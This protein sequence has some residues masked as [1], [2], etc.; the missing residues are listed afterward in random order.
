MKVRLTSLPESTVQ[1]PMKVQLTSVPETNYGTEEEG[2]PSYIARNVA[3]TGVNVASTA[4][5]LPTNILGALGTVGNLVGSG[6][7]KLRD[8]GG[9]TEERIGRIPTEKIPNIS[10]YTV[11]PLAKALLPEGYTQPQTPKEERWDELTSDITSLMLPIKGLTTGMKL[12]RAAG[13]AGA[14]GLAKWA[15]HEAGA[16]EGTQTGVK[17]GTMLGMSLLGPTRMKDYMTKQYE[18]AESAIPKSANVPSDQIEKSFEGIEKVLSKGSMTPSKKFMADRINEVRSKIK[19]GKIPVDE[20][21]EF[22]RNMNEYMSDITSPYGIQK[23]LPTITKGLNE[24]LQKYGHENKAFGKAF[25]EAEDFYRGMNN[26]TPAAKFLK[27][28]VN[29]EKIGKVTAG[30]LMGYLP[31]AVGAKL[32]GAGLAAKQSSAMFSMVKNS[33]AIRR[34]YG[35]LMQAALRE[36]VP[37]FTKNLKQLDTQISKEDPANSRE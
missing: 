8:I 30:M 27:K 2:W 9:T 10:E 19:D 17:L 26:L 22:K 13:I 36:N 5:N 11:E 4:A 37:Q 15:A 16:G 14:G 28:H 34:Y 21:W 35:N 7:N 12:G 3:R 31:P 29:N 18:L 24:T 23:K 32:I 33:P 20:A 1:Q 6:L 25:N